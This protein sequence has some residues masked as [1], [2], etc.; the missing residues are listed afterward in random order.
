MQRFIGYL[1]GLGPIGSAIANLITF[2]T[3][4]WVLTVSALIGLWASATESI[5]TFALNPRVQTAILVFM[6][7]LWTSIGLTYLVDR[8]RPRFIKPEH[9]YRYGLTFE[10]LIPAYN[11]DGGSLGIGIQVRNFSSGPIRYTI[12]EF[13]VRM[14][15]RALPKIK[16]GMLTSF[17]PRG[18][19]RTS[20]AGMFSAEDLK[21]F[22]GKRIEGT[23]N[24]SIV[25]GHPESA[26]VRRLTMELSVILE[27]KESPPIG[28]GSTIDEESDVE[29]KP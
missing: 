26:P 23:V 14:G 24:F 12:E 15:S 25:Y 20:V 5:V 17:M 4:N 3:T 28:F 11:E 10:G 27:M 6:A 22:V 29:I 8:R 13:D 1:R 19:G 21:E 16:K 9:D 18:A 2:A 7:V